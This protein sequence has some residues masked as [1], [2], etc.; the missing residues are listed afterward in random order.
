VVG[1]EVFDRDERYDTRLDPIVRVEARRLRT[2]LLEYYSGPGQY[3]P[4]R[5]EYPKGQYVPIIRRSESAPNVAGRSKSLPKRLWALGCAIVACIAVAIGYL[6]FRSTRQPVI[7]PIPASA[8]QLPDSGADPV[9]ADVAEAVDIELAR[10]RAVDVLAWPM[11]EQRI[12]RG[13]DL[14]TLAARLGASE[15]MYVLVRKSAYEHRVTVFLIDEPSGRKRLAFT[16]DDP[17]LTTRSDVTA[18]AKKIAGDYSAPK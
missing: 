3:E 17:R 5:L 10:D 1:R 16:Y 7:A 14:R 11:I 2:R 12:V 13:D 15:L 18:L 6:V 4:I 9:D 8:V